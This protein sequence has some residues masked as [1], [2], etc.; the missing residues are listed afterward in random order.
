MNNKTVVELVEYRSTKLPHS[1][2]SVESAVRLKHKF[3]D[4]V[5]IEPPSVFND[6]SWQITPQGW[7]GQIPVSPQLE[8]R[9]L[10]KA[11]LSSLFGMLN[12]AY[13]L[14]SLT[15]QQ[16]LTDAETLREFYSQLAG[17]LAN[18]VLDRSWKGFYHTYRTEDDQLPFVRGRVD[19]MQAASKPWS[20]R[21][22]CQY[23]DHT[24]DIDDNRILTWTLW[25]ILRSGYC[26]EGALAV[27]R[28][29]YRAIQPV[30]ELAPYT[31]HDCSSRTY[32]RLN[33]DYHPLH[34]ISRFF[35][36]NSGPTHT[37]GQSEM[38][39]FLVNMERLFELFVA[40]WLA[41]NLPP[42]W[43]LKAKDNIY[44]DDGGVYR[45]IPDLV[46]Y[47]RRSGQACYILDTKYKVPD[48]PSQSDI[49][50]VITYAHMKQSQEA[51]LVYPTQLIRLV[52]ARSH[53]IHVRSVCFDLSGNL[54]NAG[55]Q[56]LVELRLAEDAQT[57][58]GGFP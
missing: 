11:P 36:E 41:K 10:P 9:L 37:V 12:Y 24:A 4:Q 52:D 31:A 48:Q 26:N 20:L 58:R 28:K 50:Q 3:C 43:T 39:P 8:L 5:S 13:N 15:F 55:R 54:E 38:V 14:P 25:R 30:T 45:F 17:L 6:H 18:R 33:Q 44:L 56:F 27:V 49:S 7:V 2:L 53:G 51:V 21:L 35:L 22:Q 32:Q 19:I 47:D 29:A 40:K 34:A 57:E 16:G 1:A 42:P 46:I 23:Q